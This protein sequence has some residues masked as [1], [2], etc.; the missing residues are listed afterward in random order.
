MKKDI[1]AAGIVAT[2]ME[3]AWENVAAS[4]ERFCLT[5]GVATLA[6]M[7]ARDAARL[8]GHD[9]GA[10]AIGV[11]IAGDAPRA[12]S[13][14]MAARSA[15]SDH[16]SEPVMAPS[17]RCRAGKPRKPRTGSGAGR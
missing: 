1:T 7:M 6:E 11:A 9:M 5:A 14:S 10:T 2:G 3:A 15:S 4:F 8:C 12:S 17:W 13:A 16:G